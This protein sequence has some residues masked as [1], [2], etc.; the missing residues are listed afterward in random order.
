MRQKMTSF[1]LNKTRSFFGSSR[2]FW[3]FYKS[4]IKTIKS[5]SSD[6]ITNIKTSDAKSSQN[7]SEAAELFYSH[8]GNFKLPEI[9]RELDCESYLNN[10]FREIKLANKLKMNVLKKSSN[11]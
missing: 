9:V 4:V 7:C 8:F 5:R 6:L 10:H 11:N 3:D 1:F 2:K